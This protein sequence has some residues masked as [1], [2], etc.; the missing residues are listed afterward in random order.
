MLDEY[1]IIEQNTIQTLEDKKHIHKNGVEYWLAREIQGVL[2]YAEWRNFNEAIKRAKDSC[3]TLSNNSSNHFVDV[4]KVVA[5]NDGASRQI[6]DIALTRYS[7]YLI[8]MNGDPTKPE[9]AGAQAYFAEKTRRQELF[10]Q[11]TE[12]EK[13]LLIR[14]RIK[15]ENSHLSGAAKQAGVQ[16]WAL[17]HD[18]G[19]RGLYG[20]LGVDQIKEKK[21]ISSDDELLDCVGRTELAANE[22]RITQTEAKLTHKKIHGDVEARET[23]REVAG[24][25]R[26][27]IQQIGGVLPE[28]LPRAPSIKKLKPSKANKQL[29]QSTQ[30]ATP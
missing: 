27:T 17:F 14:D 4:N 3:D 15:T 23:H 12:T 8:A 26:R 10:E 11:L 25:V 13:R 1:Q 5:T 20:G 19:Y 29:P 28:A 6:S 22:F 16:N 21:G 9:I 18:A 7:C 24:A 30:G 2:G